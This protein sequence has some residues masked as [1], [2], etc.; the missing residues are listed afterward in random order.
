LEKSSACPEP[1]PSTKA[2]A[3]AMKTMIAI[4][5]I[6]ANQNSNSP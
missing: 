5:L 2:P 3:S 1:R 6:D 4:T